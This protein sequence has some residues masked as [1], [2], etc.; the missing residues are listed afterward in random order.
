MVAETAEAGAAAEAVGLGGLPSSPE[1]E[2]LVV[3]LLA[4]EAG[5]RQAL[6]AATVGPHGRGSAAAVAAEEGQ[7]VGARVE[8]AHE[9]A[10][11]GQEGRTKSGGMAR[12]SSRA[13]ICP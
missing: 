4:T 12:T 5:P 13:D 1:A 8:E 3:S 9:V 7:R 2:D 10:G 11:R 6:V